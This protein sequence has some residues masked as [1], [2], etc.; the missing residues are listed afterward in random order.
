MFRVLGYTLTALGWVIVWG[1]LLLPF[2]RRAFASEEPA[3]QA[4]V[5]LVAGFRQE[6]A[7]LEAAK[8]S[9]DPVVRRKHHGVMTMVSGVCSVVLIG[10]SV[11]LYQDGYISWM[12]A[13]ASIVAPGICVYHLAQWLRWRLGA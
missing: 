1:A 10:L 5:G 13:A 6:Q 2:R 11:A 8:T 9:T 3:E 7:R 4:A 12:L